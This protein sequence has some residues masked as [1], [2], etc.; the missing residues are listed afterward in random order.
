MKAAESNRAAAEQT[1]EQQQTKTRSMWCTFCRIREDYDPAGNEVDRQR[2]MTRDK[3]NKDFLEKT[4]R[5]RVPHQI[6]QE[7]KVHEFAGPHLKN[8]WIDLW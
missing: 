6:E 2:T 5:I 3:K 8:H 7:N 4:G 1:A